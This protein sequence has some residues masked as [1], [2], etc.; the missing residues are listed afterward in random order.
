MTGR[1]GHR[2]ED[3][4]SRTAWRVAA[5][6][7]FGH[8]VVVPGGITQQ[9][10]L[11][12]GD[13]AATVADPY[14]DGGMPRSFAGGHLEALKTAQNPVSHVLPRLQVRDRTQ[15]ALQMREL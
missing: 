9:N 6:L 4:M 7:A 15:A 3:P 2:V 1:T 5:L 10:S 14:A 12:R 13:D 8:V 11:R